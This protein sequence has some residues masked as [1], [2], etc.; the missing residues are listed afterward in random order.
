MQIQ[1]GDGLG[2]VRTN[3]P[4]KRYCSLLKIV[5]TTKMR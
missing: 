1:I 3:M 2:K 5:K 4:A